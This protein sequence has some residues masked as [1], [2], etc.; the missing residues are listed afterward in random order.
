M[1]VS[2]NHSVEKREFILEQQNLVK[3]TNSST[4]FLIKSNSRKNRELIKIYSHFDKKFRESNNKKFTVWKS[5]LK[6]YHAEKF[7]VKPHNKNLLIL[8]L[9]MHD[10]LTLMRN[11]GSSGINKF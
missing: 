1:N 6:R 10:F 8:P 3:V 11:F 4:K 7:S 9:Q 2:E 5:T